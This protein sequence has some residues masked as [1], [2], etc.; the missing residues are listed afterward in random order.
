[1]TCKLKCPFVITCWPWS[2]HTSLTFHIFDFSEIA[3][4]NMANPDMTQVLIV[5]FRASLCLQADPSTKITFPVSYYN[6]AETFSISPK[7]F[8]RSLYYSKEELKV[9]YLGFVLVDPSDWLRHFNFL[10]C[11]R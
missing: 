8:N 4:Q 10:I 9:L 7:S 6:V 2:V 1:M 3:Q 11:N 5:F